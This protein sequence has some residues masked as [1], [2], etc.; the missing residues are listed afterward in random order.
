MN[1][2]FFKALIA[3]MPA[4]MLFSGSLIL[5]RRGKSFW[6]FL[7]LLGAGFLIVV[8][9]THVCEALQLFPWM[10]WGFSHSAGHYLDFCS[11]AL[12]LTLFPMGYLLDALHK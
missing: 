3:L 10:Q 11:A 4:S 9:L 7:Q 1:I 6:S 12:G 5:F 2:T 8:P